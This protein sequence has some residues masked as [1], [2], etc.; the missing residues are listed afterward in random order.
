[1][2]NVSWIACCTLL[3]GFGAGALA[4]QP[5][6]VQVTGHVVGWQDNTG[7]LSPYLPLSLPVTATYIY[8][9]SAPASSMGPGQ[10]S[11]S[12][13]SASLV[14]SMGPFTFQTDPASRMEAQ[15]TQGVPGSTWGMA[16]FQGYQN[17]SLPNGV[18]VDFIGVNFLDPTGQWP[19]SALLPNAAP[20][21]TSYANSQIVVSGPNTTTGYF[22]ITT[23]I[24]WVQLLPPAIEVSPQTGSF[25]PQQHFDA[26]V[27]LP[28]GGA[29]VATMQASVGGDPLALNYPGTCQLATPT[30]SGR[31]ALL[32]PGADAA[33][34]SLQGITQ[35]DWQVTLTDGSSFTQSVQWSLIR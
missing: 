9:P 33:L 6:S 10:Y 35:I 32:C 7:L 17:P 24:D 31:A 26:A 21:L 19:T 23:Q 15:I 16:E 3:T 29:S 34:V 12:A 2:K 11:L 27:L 18:D 22:Q 4:A 25:I 13:S 14:V 28:L 5:I 20:N 30:S 1:M 8:D